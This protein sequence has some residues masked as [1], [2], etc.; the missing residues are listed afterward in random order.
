MQPLSR[1][2]FLC[3]SSPLLQATRSASQFIRPSC[4]FVT[5]M[6][7][8]QEILHVFGLAVDFR[9]GCLVRGHAGAFQLQVPV[10]FIRHSTTVFNEEKIVQGRFCPDHKGVPRDPVLSEQGRDAAQKTAL[11][12]QEKYPHT[13]VVITSPQA[14]AQETA[15]I[16]FAGKRVSWVVAEAFS[17]LHV[18]RLEGIPKHE[19]SQ[20]DLHLYHTQRNAMHKIGKTGESALDKLTHLGNAL[21][22]I[23]R[24][25]ADQ[26]HPIAVVTHSNTIGL[27]K[28]LLGTADAKDIDGVMAYRLRNLQTANNEDLFFPRASI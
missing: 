3:A 13:Q 1:L 6:H 14:R 4:P 23:N 24:R 15:R 9:T 12:I 17:E 11:L 16:L 5:R 22:E 20:E 8:T 19:Q 7:T 25:Y 21:L 28:V 26:E 18:G 27:L 2:S 10:A